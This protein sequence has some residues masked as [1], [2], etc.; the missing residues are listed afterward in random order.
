MYQTH[1]QLTRTRQVPRVVIIGA[2][3]GGL[4]AAH[5]LRKAPVDVIVIDQR[6][7][8]LFQP[9]LYQVATA[10]LSP[11]EIA[12]PIRS[13]LRRQ[14]NAQVF[15]GEVT[16]I[17]TAQHQVV[18]G[19]RRE[20]YDYLIVATGARHAYFGHDDW[21]PNAPGLK[22]L[23]DALEI[24]RRILTAFE[25]AEICEDPAQRQRLLTFVI[26]GGGP[27]G[28]ELAGALSELARK[29]LTTDFR[30]I[31]TRMTRIVLV[32]AGS[33]VLTAFPESLSENARRSLTHLGV[34]IRFGTAV[35]QVDAQGV[36]LADERIEAT[37]VLW[38]AGVASSP[39]ARWLDVEHDRA[40]RAL[41]TADLSIPGH[42]E[43]FVIGDAALAKGDNDKP[44]PGIATVA[45]QQGRYVARLIS[46]KLRNEILPGPFR[47]HN[48]GNL[49]TIGRRT[50]VVDFGWLRLQG[51][52][53]WGIWC[54]A[55]ILFLIG[56][57]NR[58]VV[59]LDW[60]I[61]YVTFGRG[62]RLITGD[63]RAASSEDKK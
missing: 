10:G 2:G 17:D 49:A 46:A 20:L 12:S 59:A 3:F 45:K 11:A 6:N 18:F 25:Q 41:V 26:I 16:A 61:S 43:I 62:A 58:V 24:R 38:A 55:H 57:R 23:E 34:E 44:L 53:A 50:A 63:E 29:A 22:T 5:A 39:A 4:N 35:T 9:L 28:V 33:R 7:H 30:N 14:R 27:T 37:T 36:N 52:I 47:Y 15:L 1:A 60:I 8:H 56:F 51:F 31:D 13:V 19:E 48:P 32:E 21:E 42:A 54:V 40:G